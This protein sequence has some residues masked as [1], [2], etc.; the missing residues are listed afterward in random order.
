MFTIDV[1]KLSAAVHTRFPTTLD[2]DHE[3]LWNGSSNRQVENGV[4]N[5]RT[6]FPTFDNLINF[7]PL[8]KKNDLNLWSMTLKFN[9]VLAVV[10]VMFIQN[11]IKPSAAVYELSCGQRKFGWKQYCRRY[12]GQQKEMTLVKV[13]RT[14]NVFVEQIKTWYFNC[15]NVTKLPRKAS[16]CRSIITDN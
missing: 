10:K 1:I 13:Y 14:M 11:F 15:W 16:K 3:Y 12:R 5:Y 2:F 8:K 6:T 7:S 4:I 9:S